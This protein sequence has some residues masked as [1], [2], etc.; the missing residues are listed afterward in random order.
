MH[1]A[2]NKTIFRIKEIAPRKKVALKLLHHILGHRSTRSFMAVFTA[3]VWKYNKLRIYTETFCT[4]C[5]I[6]PMKKKARYKYVLNPKAHFE[7]V[8]RIIF[9]QQNQNV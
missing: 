6:S 7:W 1:F 3:N 8:L 4:S 9:Q 2:E 5:H